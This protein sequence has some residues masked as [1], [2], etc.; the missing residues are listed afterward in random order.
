[1]KFLREA[2]AVFQAAVVSTAA[3]SQAVAVFMVADS[4]VVGCAAVASASGR[5][6]L[7]RRRSPVL[8]VPV[9]TIPRAAHTFT[10]H[11][12]ILTPDTMVAGIGRGALVAMAIMVTAGAGA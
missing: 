7:F 4:R 10:R 3:G 11:T 2:V 1:M 5:A 9:V 6:P 8:A 12:T